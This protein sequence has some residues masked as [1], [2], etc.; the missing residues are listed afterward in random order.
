[1]K[2]ITITYIIGTDNIGQGS[3]GAGA[4]QDP[5]VE[6]YRV[7][8]QERLAAAYPEVKYIDVVIENGGSKA[9]VEGLDIDDYEREDSM[10]EEI[11]AIA[12][13]VWDRGEWHN[14]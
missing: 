13:D 5:A 11:K 14:A 9:R 4:E 8:V 12:N 3:F 2:N 6:N 1:M 10:L 7:E